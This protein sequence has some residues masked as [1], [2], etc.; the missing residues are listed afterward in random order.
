MTAS[1]RGY[2]GPLAL[3]DEVGLARWQ[4]ERAQEAGMIPARDHSRGWLPEQVE[5]VRGLVAGIV[6]RFGAERPVGLHKCASRLAARLDRPVE[7]DD[8]AALVQAGH[9]TAVEVFKGYDL[10]APAQVDALPPKL[11]TEVVDARL[12]WENA[13]MPVQELAQELGWSRDEL[14]AVLAERGVRAGQDWRIANEVAERLRADIALRERVHADR[15][16]AV[17]AAGLLLERVLNVEDGRRHVEAAVTL[18]LLTTGPAPAMHGRRRH[19]F[20]GPHYRTGDVEALAER[21]RTDTALRERVRAEQTITADAAA[22]LL[23][24]LLDVQ[25][26]RRHFDLAVKAKLIGAVD[27]H[28]KQVGREKWITIPLYRTGDVESLAENSVW[29]LVREI[30]P[31]QRSPLW[32]LVTERPPE[33][34]T[35]L[36]RW[37]R[38]L[39][40]AH[41]VEVWGWYRPGAKAWEIDWERTPES[42]LTR[43]QVMASL[44]SRPELTPHRKSITIGSAA[45]AAV[46]FARAML[47]QGVAVILD[48]E[49]VSL[50]GAVCEIAVIDACTGRTLL[51][52]L[53]NPGVPIE[54]GAYAVHGITDS[55]VTAPGVPT[56]PIVYKRLLRATAGK[57]VLAYNASYDR[58]VIT[59]DCERHGMRRS[60]L[61]NTEHWADVMVPRSEHA[62]SRRLLRNG[63]GHR[64]LGDV[65]QTRQHLLRMTAP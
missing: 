12:G 23:E 47:E 56:W 43:D 31:G 16:M 39:G 15:P 37:L 9:L 38:D 41:G 2:L 24:N 61:A 35:L 13:S 18:G 1:T 20:T 30:G 48:T 44:I 3:A 40:D 59:F 27:S 7:A 51:D 33:R 57:I 28:E 42:A 17:V 53:V 64:A 14:N 11:V 5:Q 34:A 4:F 32:D 19:S 10:Y 6:Q 58:N 50:G 46:N 65:Q 29:H 49:T 26:A 25:G 36:R 60:R 45:G 8:V 62:Y 52:T 22:S 55:E 63:G 21:L 54:A